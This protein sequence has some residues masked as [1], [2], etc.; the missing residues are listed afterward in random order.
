MRFKPFASILA[1]MLAV[2]MVSWL[3]YGQAY[4]NSWACVSIMLVVFSLSCY[5]LEYGVYA[6]VMELV[7]GSQGHLLDLRPG[8]SLR[9]GIFLV[10]CLATIIQ[11][12]RQRQIAFFQ[13]Q[14]WKWY[15]ALMISIAGGVMVGL[16]YHNNLANIFFDVNGY[17]FI[18]F[19]FPVSQAI[20]RRE[21]FLTIITIIFTGLTLLLVQTLGIIFMY[22]HLTTF[23][24]YIPALY[25]WMQDFHISEITKFDNG[26]SRVFF[27]SDMYVLYAFFIGLA[28]LTV[29][30]RWQTY[31][32][33]GLAVLLIFLSYS[34]SFWVATVIT[35]CLFLIY[36]RVQWS[37]SI[38]SL[39]KLALT[40]IG[41]F[42]S[43]YM[44]TLAIIHL[45]LFTSTADISVN[46]LL[47]ERTDQFTSDAAAGSRM[48]LLGP[49]FSTNLQYPLF[50]HGFGATVTYQ[51]QDPRLLTEKNPTGSYTTFSF[52]WGYLDLWLKLGLIGCIVYLLFLS[53]TVRQA[54]HTISQLTNKQD[55]TILI[56]ATFGLVSLIFVHGLTPYL[57]HP[58]GISWFVLVTQLC[59]IYAKSTR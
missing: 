53:K 43:G 4:W 49:L 39:G 44:F 3:V 6:I 41:L 7:I 54:R 57:N 12:I 20:H 48:A 14:F 15:L 27:Q 42:I 19:I 2:V 1:I 28:G 35:F 36:Y 26:F 9:T 30:A 17:L 25:R 32:L 31:I 52:E 50:G 23:Q 5:K 51:S 29:K 56:G 59:F 46:S 33:T 8:I 10:V 24:Y 45:P 18:G 37:Y 55:R 47:T 38:G 22:S 40:V 11:M 21:Q 58:L 16:L 13:T 34:R